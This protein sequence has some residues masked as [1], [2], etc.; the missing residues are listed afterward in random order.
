MRNKVD[1]RKCQHL[2]YKVHHPRYVMDRYGV[3]RLRP[4]LH[5]YYCRF[6]MSTIKAF[7]RYCV[8]YRDIHQISLKES[9]T[10]MVK[11][12][13]IPTELDR[14]ELKDLPQNVDLKATDERM[15]KAQ[16][17]KTGGLLITFML[18]G[19]LQFPQKYTKVS[20]SELLKAMKKL[21]LSDTKQLQDAWYTYKLTVMRIGQPRMIP[22][23]K[24]KEQD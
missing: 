22:I 10:T 5:V 1:C 8:D 14:I 15:V 9:E 18:R 23:S 11:L 21:K 24:A 17:G 12:D 13:N 20:G 7:I 2:D 6:R 4:L 3:M 16:T 19:G